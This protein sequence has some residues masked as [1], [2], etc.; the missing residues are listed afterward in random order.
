[1]LDGARLLGPTAVRSPTTPLSLARAA[2]S[3]SASGRVRR[4]SSRRAYIPGRRRPSGFVQDCHTFQRT[5]RAG[6]PTGQIEVEEK[7]LTKGLFG[8]QSMFFNYMS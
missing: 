3:A 5:G 1:M 4:G 6:D 8:R 2:T 7:I